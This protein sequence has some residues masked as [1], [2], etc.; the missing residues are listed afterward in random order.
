MSGLA[1]GAY[2]TQVRDF[3]KVMESFAPEE[4]ALLLKFVTACSKPPLLGFK[5][6]VRSLF[7]ELRVGYYSY[8]V[9]VV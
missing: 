2:S 9:L 1:P 5:H 3:W 8:V 7:L 6:L 4:R